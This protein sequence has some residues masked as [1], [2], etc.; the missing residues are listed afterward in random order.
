MRWASS[1][2]EI[3]I[4]VTDIDREVLRL[5]L[6]KRDDAEERR[7]LKYYLSLSSWS[8]DKLCQAGFLESPKC[9]LCGDPN[10][11]MMHLLH[12]CSALK[13]A[14]QLAQA[15][16]PQINIADLPQPL[17]VGIPLP[18]LP[19]TQMRAKYPLNWNPI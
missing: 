1:T 3:L 5:A 11:T 15:R 19:F 12:H 17:Q 8:N 4:G 10:Q 18:I 14:R 2:R 13:E 9:E 7:I 16:I 6:K